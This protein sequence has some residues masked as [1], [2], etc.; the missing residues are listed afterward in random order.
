MVR[1]VISSDSGIPNIIEP[2]SVLFMELLLSK[3]WEPGLLELANRR[4]RAAV[5]ELHQQ[6]PA[7]IRPHILGLPRAARRPPVPELT[8]AIC[9]GMSPGPSPAHRQPR[10][11]NNA[12]TETEN[13]QGRNNLADQCAGTGWKQTCPA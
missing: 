5:L 10:S 7:V 11:L 6:Y 12:G 13:C 2:N 9:G 1:E 4:M 3:K 8:R